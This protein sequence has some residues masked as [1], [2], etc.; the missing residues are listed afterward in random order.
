MENT[1]NQNTGKALH[2]W[3]YYIQPSH[4]VPRVSYIDCLGHCSFYGMI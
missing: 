2:I 4:Y 1:A 3:E